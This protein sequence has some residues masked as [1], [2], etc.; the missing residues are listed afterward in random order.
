M[1]TLLDVLKLRR[2]RLDYISPPICPI[3]SSGSGSGVF[4]ESV[5]NPPAPT[6]LRFSGQC[7]KFLTWDEYHGLICMSLLRAVDSN[8]PTGPAA[9]VQEC[10]SNKTAWVASPGWWSIAP[11]DSKGQVGAKSTP[12]LVDFLGDSILLPIP[13]GCDIWGYAIFKNPDPADPNG[14]QELVLSAASGSFSF[15]ITDGAGCYL[16]QAITSEGVS[17]LSAPVCRDQASDCCPTGTCSTDYAWDPVLCSCYPDPY[18]G[19]LGPTNVACLSVAYSSSITAIQAAGPCV[20]VLVSGTVPP[21]LALGLG[22]VAGNT[23]SLS[24]TPTTADNYTFTVKATDALGTSK[25]NTF[26]IS[27]LGI[28]QLVLPDATTDTAYSEQLTAGGGV[29]PYTFAVIDGA[30]PEGITLTAAGL[31]SGSANHSGSYSFEISVTDSVGQVCSTAYSFVVLSCPLVVTLLGPTAVPIIGTPPSYSWNSATRLH[32]VLDLQ[33]RQ[34]WYPND[35][36]NV[37]TPY[38]RIAVFDTASSTFIPPATDSGGL[39]TTAGM[40]DLGN[41]EGRCVIDTKFNQAIFIGNEEWW[42]N[43]DLSSRNLISVTKI[44]S[45][46]GYPKMYE[47]QPAYDP[48]R[49]RIYFHWYLGAL[50]VF[51]YNCQSSTVAGPYASGGGYSMVSNQFAFVPST[52]TL[53][54]SNPD[55]PNLFHKW[56]PSSF[57]FTLNQGPAYTGIGGVRY[58]RGLGMLV[59]ET[60]TKWVFIDPATDL[61]VG[62]YSTTEKIRW[63]E[64]NLCDPNI[65]WICPKTLQ[66]IYKFLYAAPSTFTKASIGNNT[67][68]LTFHFDE[69][70][71]RLFAMSS[72][73]TSVEEYDL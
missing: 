6:G 16:L 64:G 1:N 13:S 30:L 51:A 56:N 27:V 21:G 33:R 47:T 45:G 28:N 34:L 54:I 7:G 52:D 37:T 59:F 42:A 29:A 66:F 24:G 14:V 70:G 62:E 36:Y 20:W 2:V 65:F 3:I 44:S 67:P 55:G 41:S 4:V 8:D 53:Y 71:K 68:Y 69:D 50:E 73:G 39:I 22:S 31:L 15:E 26:S 12:V 18:S 19:I 43:Y 9:M 61:V 11:I 10:V 17:E 57:A 5:D 72:T 58:I 63:S 40:G 49:G 38:Q 23:T 35:A 46:S 25:E 48:T 32:S 60:A